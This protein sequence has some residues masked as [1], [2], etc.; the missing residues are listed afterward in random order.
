M[1]V[2]PLTGQAE[3]PSEEP[4]ARAEE[5]VIL[6]ECVKDG[7]C[8]VDDFVLLFMNLI[9]FFLGLVSLLAMYYFIMGGFTLMISSGQPEKIQAGKGIIVNA[10]VGIFCVLAAWVLINTIYIAVSGGS[11]EVF[12]RPWWQLPPRP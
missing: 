6:P 5:F 11:S 9:N 3:G 2:F 10:L 12:G 4:P 8:H 1:I 7:N